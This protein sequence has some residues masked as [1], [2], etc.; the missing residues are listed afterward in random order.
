MANGVRK[1]RRWIWPLVIV[2]VSSAASAIFRRQARRRRA[3]GARSV[4]DHDGEARR[5]GHRGARDGQGAAAREGRDQV[6]GVGPGGQGVRRR[7]RPREEG[8][9]PV[10][11]RSGRLRAAGAPSAR[12]TWPR[13]KNALEFSRAAACR[14]ARTG[15]KERG[16]AQ[17]DV[18]TAAADVK[19]KKVAVQTATVAYNAASDQLRYTRIVAPMDGTVTE[20]GIQPGEVVTPGV[21]ATFEGK[22]LLD[23]VGSVDAAREGRPE[24]DRRGQGEARAE[25]DGHARRAA[26]QD[27]RRRRSPR[28]R[29]RRSCRR[30]SRS[31]CSPSRRR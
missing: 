23:G 13:R 3:E 7:R 14:A 4:A 9:A 25:G 8:A 5:S 31:T 26:G 6:E 22:A 15:S 2:V 29:R 20:R 24:P 28:S 1:R 11:A 17:M 10:A 21:Q 19:M 16:V 27:L 30:T 18:D 12:P